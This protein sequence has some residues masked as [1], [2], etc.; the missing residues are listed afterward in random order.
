MNIKIYS[1]I[2]LMILASQVCLPVAYAKPERM[3]LKTVEQK[4]KHDRA[5]LDA[6]SVKLSRIQDPEARKAIKAILT[7]LNLSYQN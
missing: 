2:G 5:K 1:M 4:A 6:K 3:Q 7:D